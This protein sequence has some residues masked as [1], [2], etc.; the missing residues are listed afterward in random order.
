[1]RTLENFLDL[2][3]NR[4]TKKIYKHGLKRYLQTIYDSNEAVEELAD[5][6]FTQPRDY[7]VDIQ[8]FQQS[9]ARY[10]PKTIRTHL[11][12]VK[13]FHIENGVELSQRFWRR[14]V[15]RVKGNRARTRDRI[16]STQELREI[17]MHLP[18]IGKALFLFL[19]SSGARIGEALQIAS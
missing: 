17:L 13:T 11:A 16:P 3:P 9:I 1:M 12:I 6:Y 8:R 10:A 5:R 15:R 18:L 14:S 4:N 7:K 19:S 2:Y